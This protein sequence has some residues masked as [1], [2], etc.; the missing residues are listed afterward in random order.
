MSLPRNALRLWLA[1]AL[2]TPIGSRPC[3]GDE[4]R[5]RAVP[6]AIPSPGGSHPISRE[7][8]RG[9]TKAGGSGGFWIGTVGIGL[10]LAAFGG[11]SLAAKRL[12]PGG[13]DSASLRVVGRASLS[14][15]HAV[16]LLRAGDRV[17]IVGTG[18]GGPPSLL[19]EMT[20]DATLDRLLA[21]EVRPVAAPPRPTIG[22]G[23]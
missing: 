6:A 3:L 22:G 23:R 15:K 8:A 10:A 5:V 1:V 12:R 13:A 2:V 4:G 19:G 20:D 11:L 14:P 16:Y 9:A 21:K 18:N 7:D 17:L